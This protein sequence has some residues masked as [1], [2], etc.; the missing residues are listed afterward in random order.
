MLVK[1]TAPIGEAVSVERAKERLRI[2]GTADD[3]DLARVIEAATAAVEKQTGL[4]LRATDFELGLDSWHDWPR[5][6]IQLPAAPVRAVTEVVYLDADLVEQTVDAADY[7]WERTPE[8]AIVDFVEGFSR[9][10]LG[11]RPHAVKVRFSAGFDAPDASG[12]GD[13]PELAFPA[14]AEMAVLFLVGHWHQMRE[15]VAPGEQ[16][17][18]PQAFEYLAGQLRI[19]R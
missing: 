8:G 12:S 11:D 5:G 19:Y 18:V 17:P 14:T 1:L 16:F 10:P 7:F 4:T 6:C 13:D 3:A 15:S 9:P 2:D